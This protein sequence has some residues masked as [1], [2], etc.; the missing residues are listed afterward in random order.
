MDNNKLQAAIDAAWDKR[1]GINSATK[2]EAREA[3][4]AALDGLDSGAFRVAE[5]RDGKWHTN[6]WLKKALL[7]SFRLNDSYL[8]PGGGDFGSDGRA[9]WY[10]KVPSKFAGWNENRF[11]AAGF[12]AVPGCAVRR[13]P[14]SPRRGAD[15][16][17]RQ[18]RR[19]RRQRHHDRY[20]GHHRLLRPDRQELPHLRRCRHRRR[21]GAAAGRAGD[22]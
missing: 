21:A 8:M 19:A 11:K 12:R 4:E 5:K 1:D 20:L 17:L 10:D 9:A 18:C 2:G 15:A 7:L 14:T 16:Q 3:V 22:Y 13:R 6:Q